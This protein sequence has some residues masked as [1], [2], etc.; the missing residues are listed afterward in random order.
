MVPHSQGGFACTQLSLPG[1]DS[2]SQLSAQR[3]RSIVPVNGGVGSRKDLRIAGSAADASISYSN[4]LDGAFPTMHS[5]WLTG[6]PG[7]NIDLP[8]PP[9]E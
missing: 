8:L 5:H 1:P 4:S 6:T 3:C 2:Q 7:T 9:T